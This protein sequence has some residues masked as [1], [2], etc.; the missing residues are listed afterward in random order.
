[1]VAVDIVTPRSPI[2]TRLIA[3]IEDIRA[4]IKHADI[5]ASALLSWI[6][7][8][9]VIVAAVLPSSPSGVSR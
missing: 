1:V 9:L 5:K 3:E 7:A 4:T 6:G 2:E 8:V